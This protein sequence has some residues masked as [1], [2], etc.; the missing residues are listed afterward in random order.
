LNLQKISEEKKIFPQNEIFLGKLRKIETIKAGEN[1]LLNKRIQKDIIKK[2]IEK[3]NVLLDFDFLVGEIL[4]KIYSK[5]RI[6]SSNV[7][8]KKKSKMKHKKIIKKTKCETS[9]CK[10]I[11]KSK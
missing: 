7:K 5:S 3:K 4:N 1:K 11:P 10:E 2:P 8:K 6:I 9:N